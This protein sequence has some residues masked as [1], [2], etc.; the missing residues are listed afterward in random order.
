MTI[1]RQWAWKPSDEMKSLKQCLQTLVRVVGGDGNFL[2]NVGPM[3]DGRIEPRQVERLGEM[4]RWLKKYGESI[5]AT[6]GGP[7]KPG[8]WGASTHKDNRIYLHILNWDSESIKLP[9][10]SKEIVAH[11]VLTGGTAAVKQTEEGIEISVPKEQRRDIDTIVKLHL[12]GP[13]GFGE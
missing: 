12:D 3:P 10:I 7:V 1:C 8:P 13:A 2:F 11:S 4:G 6:R 9:A 5:Y